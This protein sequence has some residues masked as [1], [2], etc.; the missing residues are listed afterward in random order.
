MGGKFKT[1]LKRPTNNNA[2]FVAINFFSAA[3]AVLEFR[4]TQ[5]TCV[6][7]SYLPEMREERE[8]HVMRKKYP[9]V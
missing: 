5:Q 1:C 9:T 7:L 6:A 4:L 2:K 8:Q 3:P